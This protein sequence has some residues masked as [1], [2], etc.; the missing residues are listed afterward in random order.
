MKV[1]E[2]MT[3]EVV[4]V[5]PSTSVQEAARLMR[6]ADIGDVVIA[7]EGRPLGILTDRDIAVRVVARGLNPSQARVGDFMSTNLF[8]GSPSQDVEEAADLM[9]QQQIRR[10]PIVDKGRLV[11]IVS[12]GD[13]AVDMEAAGIEAHSP[14]GEALEDI[15]KPAEPKLEAIHM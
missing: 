15:S 14:A 10:L 6:D 13:I 9:G 5:A 3:T 2:I 8:T 1:S 11:G 7:E 12:L 4:T